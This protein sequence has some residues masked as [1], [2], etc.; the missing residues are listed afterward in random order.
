MTI[1][2]CFLTTVKYNLKGP[3]KLEPLTESLKFNKV[4]QPHYSNLPQG[5]EFQ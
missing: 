3:I 5:L 2:K 4:P 1:P